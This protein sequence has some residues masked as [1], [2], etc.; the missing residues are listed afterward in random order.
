MN[1]LKVKYKKFLYIIKIDYIDVFQCSYNFI[2]LIHFRKLNWITD[3]IKYVNNK[4]KVSLILE[5]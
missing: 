4:T 5:N 3:H 2:K 1:I